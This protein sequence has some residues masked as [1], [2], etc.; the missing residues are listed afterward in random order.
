MFQERQS[1]QVLKYFKNTTMYH[2]K[3]SRNCQDSSQFKIKLFEFVIESLNKEYLDE[4]D[5]RKERP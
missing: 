5:W 3:M 1:S 4:R 2:F